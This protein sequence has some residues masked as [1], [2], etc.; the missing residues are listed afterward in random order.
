MKKKNLALYLLLFFVS[1]KIYSQE[2]PKEKLES[3]R[4][5]NLYTKLEGTYQLQIIDSRE[6]PTLPLT[7]MDS[8]EIK[9]QQNTTV[10]LWLKKNVRVMVPSYSVINKQGFSPLERVKYISSS[11]K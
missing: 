3:K 2:I 10:Y 11:E 7:Y 6:G 8:V 4:L 5:M 9:R 1:I